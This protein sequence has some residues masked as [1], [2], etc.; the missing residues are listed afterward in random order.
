ML[1][2]QHSE[3]FASP[4][5]GDNIVAGSARKRDTSRTPAPVGAGGKAR[6]RGVNT[7]HAFRATTTPSKS[8]MSDNDFAEVLKGRGNKG[9]RQTT[10]HR[11]ILQ[12]I[13][14]AH[15]R[16]AVKPRRTQVGASASG[17]GKRAL[18]ATTCAATDSAE[19]MFDD[20]TQDDA[21]QAA[22]PC[23]Q[24]QVPHVLCVCLAGCLCA[25]RV[26]AAACKAAPSVSLL[27][28]LNP[29]CRAEPHE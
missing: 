24:F 8:P 12:P 20:M 18:E 6:G 29:Y 7:R 25:S 23:L 13:N 27:S 10:V 1:S 19:G 21:G 2:P 22:A 5:T 15:T 28:Q 9:G 3:T 4:V 26:V 17:R 16:E 14:E 11:A